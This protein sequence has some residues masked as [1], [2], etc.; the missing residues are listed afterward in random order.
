MAICIFSTSVDLSTTDV[1]RWL[2]H[3][4]YSDVIRINCN[5]K[6]S[7]N[8][9]LI[10]AAEGT[11]SF[12]LDHQRI[13]LQDIEAVWYRKG[14]NWLADQFYPIT[15]E[16]YDAF[17]KH[18]NTKLKAE[19]A[20]LT[21]YLHYIIEHT[22]PVLGTA[23]KSDL[24]KLLVLSA[25]KETGLLIPDFFITNYKKGIQNIYDQTHSMI[26]KAMSDGLYLFE[27]IE[28]G[29]GYFTYTEKVNETVTDQLPQQISPS[30]LQKNIQKKFELRIFFLED[31]CYSM[32]ILSQADEQTKTDYRKYNENKPN[33]YVPFQLP[34]DV[35]QKIRLLFK[36]LALNTGSVD[37]I[38]DQQDNFY[39]LE[40]NPVGQFGMVSD[41]CNYFLEKKVALYL[42]EH[43]RNRKN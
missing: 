35:D 43:A 33:R 42:I 31:T 26:T 34:A 18:F 6:H 2:H 25:A 32:A 39:F 16:G 15:I 36:K 9:I 5:D 40:I 22:A 10:D 8:S 29:T 14:K 19:E 21:E 27:N 41:P 1:I 7:N 24:N 28:S 30:F 37:M 20:K 3:L 11:F 23:M 12:Q 4:G 13:H 17:T 38:V